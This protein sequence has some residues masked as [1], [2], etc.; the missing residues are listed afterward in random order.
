MEAISEADA[1]SLRKDFEDI[2]GKNPELLGELVSYADFWKYCMPSMSAE[3]SRGSHGRERARRERDRRLLRGV[4]RGVKKL[5]G[6]IAKIA[7][8]SRR[9]FRLDGLDATLQATEM[10]LGRFF[11]PSRRGPGQTTPYEGSAHVARLLEK[12]GVKLTKGRDGKLARTLQYMLDA[13]GV[14]VPDDMTRWV[15]YAVEHRND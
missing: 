10:S 13:V 2:L 14:E 15:K 8:E 12:H 3:A 9:G 6:E 4:Y 7:P 11:R 5:R 1:K